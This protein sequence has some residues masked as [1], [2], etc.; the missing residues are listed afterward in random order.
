MHR[1]G[2]ANQVTFDAS[3][4]HF[5]ILSH[6]D[7]AEGSSVKLL[8]IN[9]DTK[10]QMS[11]AI[12]E[13]IHE[14]SWRLRTILRTRRFYCDLE[15]VLHFK[16]HVLSYLEYRI[17]GIYHA[18]TTALTPLD[19]ILDRLLRDINMSATEALLNCNLAPLSSRRDIAML[20]I[21]HRVVL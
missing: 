7:S 12:T 11:E 20:D 15:L 18:I 3:K 21:I 5:S 8:G 10:L 4:E 14:A 9:F 19:R 16:S 13:C 6:T 17:A 2:F 1:W